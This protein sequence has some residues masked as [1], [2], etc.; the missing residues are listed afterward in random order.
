MKKKII[1]KQ[2]DKIDRLTIDKKLIDQ[3]L[4]LFIL[5]Y[6][7][8]FNNRIFEITH[9]KIE[10]ELGLTLYKQ[11]K[12]LDFLK[13]RNMIKI[14]KK[15][16]TSNRRLLITLNYENEVIRYLKEEHDMKKQEL[17]PYLSQPDKTKPLADKPVMMYPFKINGNSSQT[18]LDYSVQKFLQAK[19]GLIGWDKVTNRDLAGVFMQLGQHHRDIRIYEMR[20]INWA[21][22]VIKEIM[23]SRNCLKKEDFLIIARKFIRIYE[24]E[25]MNGSGLNWGFLKK[26]ITIRE[27]I[28]DKIEN[29][30]YTKSTEEK[31]AE[32]P[33]FF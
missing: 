23:S 21:G 20:K 6:F 14:E 10:R 26:H 32:M 19:F 29:E 9:E 24:E 1:I 5:R 18:I 7:I 33:D 27:K 31:T 2:K 8:D 16:Y 11:N 4:S 3:P 28:L 22:S 17:L 25:Y 30:L 15:G 12:I 13:E